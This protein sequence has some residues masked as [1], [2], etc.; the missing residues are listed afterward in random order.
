MALKKMVIGV[1]FFLMSFSVYADSYPAVSVACWK[2]NGIGACQVSVNA[3]C[4]AYYGENSN[5]TQCLYID[6]TTQAVTPHG[7][8]ANT[9]NF[10]CPS[11]GTLSGSSCISAPACVSPTIR[12]SVSPY[13]CFMPVEC[14]YPETDNGNG[15]CQNNTCPSGQTRN[16]TTNLCQTP[17]TCGS[18]Q[19]YQVLTNT[20]LLNKL[21]CPVNTHASTANDVCYP[22]APLACPAGQHDDG[23]WTCVADTPIACDGKI[24][25]AGYI[26]G[27]YQ[28]IPKTNTDQ[29][30]ADSNNATTTAQAANNS[31]NIASA[32]AK[33]ATDSYQT[34]VNALAADPT[35]TTKQAT[36]QTTGAAMSDA[37][38]AAAV[39]KSAA[40]S[41][42]KAMDDANAKAQTGL[43]NSIDQNIKGDG[44][45]GAGAAPDLSTIDSGVSA[46]IGQSGTGFI[47]NLVNL[48][49]ASSCMS[50]AMNF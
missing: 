12:S 9:P 35:N 44:S 26:N 27:Q 30:Q 8:V 28:C 45:G 22:N 48:P 41:A 4:Q 49:A 38:A 19:T 20:C 24:A 18:T 29:K 25:Q 34:A 36:V 47:D 11:G 32:A 21:A 17:P 7:S 37:N 13:A 40:D 23:T 50:L 15:I 6:P 2:A 43:L 42:N 3:A 16:P 1:V 39:T 14:H 5:G 46:N 31:N 10:G 33:G